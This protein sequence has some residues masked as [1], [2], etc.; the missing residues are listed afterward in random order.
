MLLGRAWDGATRPAFRW[1]VRAVAV[2][3]AVLVPWAAYL[4]VSL[5]AS[6]SAR[7]WPAAWAGLDVVMA[8]GLAATAWLAVRRDR[9]MTFP[10][11]S[12]A[13]LFLVD[14]WF[15]VCTAAAGRPLAMALGDMCVEV[16]EAAGC[17]AL[18]VAVWRTSACGAE[19]RACAQ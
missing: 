13:T 17:L 16:A 8:A 2:S 10:A 18:T 11:V 14:A 7:H 4:A 15:D 12:T 3:A 5:P 19:P 6:V 9:R 1:L